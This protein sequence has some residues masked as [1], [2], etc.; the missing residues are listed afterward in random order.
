MS[1]N[2]SP[3]STEITTTIAD[4]LLVNNPH[5]LLTNNNMSNNPT[6]T[7]TSSVDPIKN[8]IDNMMTNGGFAIC[9]GLPALILFGGYLH[10]CW[11]LRTHRH[12]HPYGR[13]AWIYW[14][15]QLL[16]SAGCVSLL[17]LLGTLLKSPNDS[18]GLLLSVWALLFTS[19]IVFCMV[20]MVCIYVSLACSILSTFV[21]THYV[22]FRNKTF[23]LLNEHK[24][25]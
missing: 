7:T 18:N 20:C 17:M 12:P 1:V 13:T 2:P 15:T 14:P 16:L 8:W 4:T 10:R 11:W 25:K 9:L 22:L 23:P 6:A 24:T 19:V 3:W 5:T 21:L